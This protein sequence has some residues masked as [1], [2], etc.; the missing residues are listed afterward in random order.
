MECK[1]E[2]FEYEK[3]QENRSL[4]PVIQVVF[5]VHKSKNGSFASHSIGMLKGTSDRDFTENAE[6][7]NLLNSY[8][9]SVNILDDGAGFPA[10]D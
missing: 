4:K 6:K 1:G 8:F 7:A 2:I 5:K 3:Q 9:N 10:T